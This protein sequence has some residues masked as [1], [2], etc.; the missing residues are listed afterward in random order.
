MGSAQAMIGCMP[1]SPDKLFACTTG[2][3]ERAKTKTNKYRKGAQVSEKNLQKGPLP[4]SAC[5][6]IRQRQALNGMLEE[7]AFRSCA[8]HNEQ[9]F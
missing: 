3:K 2:G 4:L 6:W 8:L 7:D 1:R 5:G 9:F